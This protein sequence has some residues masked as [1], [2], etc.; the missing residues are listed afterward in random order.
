MHA[1]TLVRAILHALLAHSGL[2]WG[3]AEPDHAS[4]NLS[5]HASVCLCVGHAALFFALASGVQPSVCGLLGHHRLLRTTLLVPWRGKSAGG[6]LPFQKLHSRL[7][8]QRYAT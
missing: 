2:C 5:Q 4:T 8:Q 1:C 3:V 7:P 6:E